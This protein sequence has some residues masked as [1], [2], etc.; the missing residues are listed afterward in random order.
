MRGPA[1]GFRGPWLWAVALLC[2]AAFVY[3]VYDIRHQILLG[4]EWHSIKLVAGQGMAEL[5]RYYPRATAIP[6]NL[7]QRFVLEHWGWSELSLRLVS[8]VSTALTLVALPWGVLQLSRSKTIALFVL[9]VFGTS[10]FWIFYGQNSRPYATY[11]LFLLAAFFF[12]H[13]AWHTSSRRHWLGFAASATAAT[14]FHLYT[15]PA[16]ASL[17][18]LAL[19]R[20]VGLMRSGERRQALCYFTGS[21]A[22]FLGF[23]LTTAALFA[24]TYFARPDK[25]TVPSGHRYRP[26]NDDFLDHTFELVTGASST[27]F[28]WVLVGLALVGLWFYWRRDRLT[29]AILLTS[30]VAC[31]LFTLLVRPRWYF[32]AIV[33]VR[34][35][36][37]LFP[38]YYLGIA[39]LLERATRLLGR[40]TNTAVAVAEPT[41]SES[42]RAAWPLAVL[43]L[44][45]AV[46]TVA[47]S[48]LPTMVSIR[49]NN[50]TQHSAYQEFYS[51]WDLSRA[52]PSDFFGQKDKRTLADIPTFYARLK[53]QGSCRLIE[54]PFSLDEYKVPYYLYQRV[55]GCSVL[56]G[57]TRH[58]DFG[59]MLNVDANRDRLE[60]ASMVDLERPDGFRHR[61]DYL[62]VHHD[63]V[64]EMASKPPK[65]S[66]EVSAALESLEPFGLEQLF[67][68]EYIT[69]F[70]LGS[71]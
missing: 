58:D 50:F 39:A 51:Q 5:W 17:S 44:S 25:R 13:R 34:Y 27:W 49:P 16:V 2:A 32:V 30:A 11:L 31:T 24:P 63:V 9:L 35:N 23:A 6:I 67:K 53:R 29:V 10:S 55:H 37:S 14:Y 28:A 3:R 18:L 62:I 68:D 64:A 8:L 65:P 4:D 59:V 22:G 19:W 48:P 43:F 60:F 42:I 57:F 38:L 15:L 21:F 71:R 54:F 41:K 66:R 70:A 69:V 61:A 36:V 33:F 12:F 26:T 47:T 40:F 56:A 1:N 46:A 20:I 7:Y 52:P 45:F